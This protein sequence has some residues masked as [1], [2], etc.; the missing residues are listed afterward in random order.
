MN[1]FSL[2]A[3]IL[4]VLCILMP[5][6]KILYLGYKSIIRDNDFDKILRA[7]FHSGKK[8]N[9]TYDTL[10]LDNYGVYFGNDKLEINGLAGFSFFQ[11]RRFNKELLSYRIKTQLLNNLPSTNSVDFIVKD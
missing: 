1:T 3:A 4:F 11:K 2:L 10:R 9:L 8:L 5:T 7:V 6:I